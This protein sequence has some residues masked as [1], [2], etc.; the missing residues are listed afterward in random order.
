M[1]H[2]T[3]TNKYINEFEVLEIPLPV[4]PLK[5]GYMLRVVKSLEVC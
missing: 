3:T 4:K 1:D 2:F 5:S